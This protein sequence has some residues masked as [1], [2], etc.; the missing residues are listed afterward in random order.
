MFIQNSNYHQSDETYFKLA[1]KSLSNA[2]AESRITVTDSKLI[3][4]YAL[5]L[6]SKISP[7]RYCKVISLLVNARRYFDVE[8]AQ[9]D[10]DEYLNALSNMKYAKHQSGPKEGKPYSKN[11]IVD[12]MKIT[13]RFFLFLDEQGLTTV[14]RKTIRE[15]Q[16]G[17]YDMNTKSEDDVLT[18]EEINALIA[19]ARTPKYKA[20]I[21]L[22]YE[23]GAR[24]IEIAN[25]R[26]KDIVVF[27]WGIQCILHDTK[28]DKIRVV[29]CVMYA[30]HVHAW[31]N[32]YPGDPT[33]ENFVFINPSG[34]P[35]HY[36]GV[37]KAISILAERAGIEKKITLH[38]FRHSRITHVLRDGMS[39]T[40]VKKAFWGNTKTV[41]IE[42]YGH[43]TSEDIRIEFMKMAGLESSIPKVDN[44]PK[45][46]TCP[47]CHMVSPPGTEY[48]PNCG[49][50][51]SAKAESDNSDAVTLLR[52]LLNQMSSEER[53][54]VAKELR[55]I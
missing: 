32:F 7:G 20:Y 47:Q 24:S 6:K 42:T 43:L 26:W 1:E 18:P 38:Q 2:I 9:V 23:T 15:T 33:G 30:N 12:W 21:G 27:P 14:P 8:Y 22:L 5:R 10:E 49:E 40:L 13:K 17:V 16:T 37:R 39:E 48:C 46:I 53:L 52:N 25:L 19:A 3:K 41:M 44:A 4:K 55:L 35:L 36:P 28:T 54:A 29:P 51:L 34:K 11:S 45:P 50:E 31:R